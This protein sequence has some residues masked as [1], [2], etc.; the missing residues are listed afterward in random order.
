MTRR[1]EIRSFR[2]DIPQDR[3]DDLHRRLADTRWPEQSATGWE[4]GTPVRYLRELAEYW[5]DEFDWRAIES[6]LNELPQYTTGIAGQPLHFLHVRSPEPEATPL[7]LAHGWPSTFAEFLRVIGPLSDPRAHGGDPADAFHVVVPSL[8]GFAFSGVGPEVGEGSTEHYTR[9]VAA[10]MD[11]LGYRRYGAQGGDAGYFV[12]T[13]LGRIAPD[14][15]LGVHVN[16]PI[17]MPAWDG[18]DGDADYTEQDRAK[19]ELLVGAESFTRY[20]YAAVQ[21]GRPTTLAIAMHHSPVGLLAWIAD[22]YHR[23][24]DP[25][26]TLPEDAVGRDA[27]LTDV[28]L[29]WFTGCFASSIRLYGEGRAWGAAPEPS[30]VPTAA[31]VFPGDTSLRVIA[32]RQHRIVRWTEYDRGGHFAAL[33]APDLLVDDIR[34]FFRTLR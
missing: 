7:V 11:R 10:L 4:K 5:H 32:E 21:S 25:A 13:E 16:G 31:A 23:W 20:G 3:I 22:M 14:R 34:A 26:I 30:G 8:P 12:A 27:L 17:T 24:S 15:V 19:L 6:D 2:I 33:E 29:Y 9:V 1:D 28:S 18:S